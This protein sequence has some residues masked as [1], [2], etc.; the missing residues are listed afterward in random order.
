[1]KM[2]INEREEKILE[3]L[4]RQNHASVEYLSGELYV[5][6]SSVRRDLNRLE[7]AGIVKRNYG[8]VVLVGDDR[9]AAPLI[10]RGGQNSGL[11]RI[12]AERAA[13]VLDDNMTVFLDD[14]TTVYHLLD[15]I[16]KRQGITVFTNNLITATR[17]IELS[18]KTYTI[19]GT[20]SH[21]TAVMCGSFA[22]DMLD[23]VY[24]DAAFV[25]SFALAENGDIYDC[26]EEATAIRRK[27]LER[28]KKKYYL[29]DSTKFNTYSAYK[30]CNV[31]DMDGAFSDKE[32]PD[33][34]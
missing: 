6:P 2:K 11:K 5:S 31:R 33:F 22:L 19:G 1:M 14:S 9:Q 18:I 28:A 30:L 25:S 29:C 24:A 15:H 12:I 20:S 4:R 3:I 27:M 7:Q 13:A 32:L 10:I 21:N 17:A 16:A 34:N 23:R 26:T 8:G